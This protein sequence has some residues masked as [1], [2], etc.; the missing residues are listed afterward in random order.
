ML[1]KHLD[2]RMLQKD[3]LADSAPRSQDQ[4]L[5]VLGRWGR[6]ADVID[7]NTDWVPITCQ[8]LRMLECLGYKLENTYRSTCVTVLVKEGD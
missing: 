6:V 1:L 8:A 4:N 2:F 5:T 7:P 3:S